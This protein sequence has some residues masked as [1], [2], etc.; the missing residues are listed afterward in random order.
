MKDDRHLYPFG[1]PHW[2]CEPIHEEHGWWTFLPHAFLLVYSLLAYFGS[3]R[4]FL[5][6][7]APLVVG[8][9][10]IYAIVQFVNRR[11]DPREQ[12]RPPDAP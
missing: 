8:A 7:A 3:L 6:Q 2:L 11:D 5:V 4:T 12:K 10:S 1:K 9:W